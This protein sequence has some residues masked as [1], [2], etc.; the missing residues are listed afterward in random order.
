[1]I[2]LTGLRRSTSAIETTPSGR[3]TRRKSAISSS[4]PSLPPARRRSFG[5]TA[6]PP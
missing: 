5:V 6:G 2:Q 4:S 3:A 1:M